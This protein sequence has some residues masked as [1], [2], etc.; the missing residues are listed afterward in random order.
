[1][2]KLRAFYTL[3]TTDANPVLFV[4]IIYLYLRLLN[5]LKGCILSPF[6]LALSALS[7]PPFFD[8]GIL[9]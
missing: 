1:M 3:R 5:L 8:L 6:T 9:E 2:V 4:S 7:Y